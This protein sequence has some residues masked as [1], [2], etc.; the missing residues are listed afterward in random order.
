MLKSYTEVSVVTQ[1]WKSRCN[2]A[3]QAWIWSGAG[4]VPRWHAAHGLQFGFAWLFQ[5]AHEWPAARKETAVLMQVRKLLFRNRFAF[6]GWNYSIRALIH[7]LS[8]EDTS[9]EAFCRM[10]SRSC[11]KMHPSE[12]LRFSGLADFFS[13]FPR[14]ALCSHQNAI[15]K[16]RP[17]T[18]AYL[19]HP[20][21]NRLFLRKWTLLVIRSFK[22]NL[23]C[24]HVC[25]LNCNPSPVPNYCPQT[26]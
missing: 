12:V 7:P 17:S 26:G 15:G 16:W 25:N 14:K 13:S 5:P 19:K 9:T 8:M 10:R 1:G 11:K 3:S 4:R 2:V 21:F 23:C 24:C 22:W 6:F 20:L 18:R